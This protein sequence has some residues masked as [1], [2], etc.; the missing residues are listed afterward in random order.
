V[1][2]SQVVADKLNFGFA[3]FNLRV[4]PS[5]SRLEGSLEDESC[6]QSC[7]LDHSY[8][9]TVDYWVELATKLLRP[10]EMRIPFGGGDYDLAQTKKS[11]DGQAMYFTL[12]RRK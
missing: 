1:W 2:I 12:R 7:H 5:S 9:G 8:K 6:Y 4:I 11:D 3:N 10:E